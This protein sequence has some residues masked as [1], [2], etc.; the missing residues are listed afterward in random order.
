MIIPLTL[1]FLFFVIMGTLISFFA[2][3]LLNVKS[4][5]MSFLTVAIALLFGVIN[6]AWDVGLIGCIAAFVGHIVGKFA[7][8]FFSGK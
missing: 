5:S 3:L 7:I 6:Q 8:G 4:Y 1:V 2:Y